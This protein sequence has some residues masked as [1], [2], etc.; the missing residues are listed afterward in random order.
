[1]YKLKKIFISLTLIVILSACGFTPIFSK[2]SVNFTI[3]KI[4]FTGDRD[5][6]EK[7]IYALSGYSNKPGKDKKILLLLNGSKN[8]KIV[9]RDAKGDAQLYKI[10]IQIKIVAESEE[11]ILIKKN[12]EKS[13]TYSSLESKTEEKSIANKLTQDLSNQIAQQIIL[14]IFQKTK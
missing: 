9:S 13:A 6:K 8:I 10:F 11:K 3:N 5:V 1:M 4:E 12:I 2:K 7:I 14:E